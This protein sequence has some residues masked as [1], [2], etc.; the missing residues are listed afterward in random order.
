[1]II[2]VNLKRENIQNNTKKIQVNKKTKPVKF[3]KTMNS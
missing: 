2:G 3:E 1:M